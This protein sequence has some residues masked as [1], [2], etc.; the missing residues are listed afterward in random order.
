M[1]DV[2]SADAEAERAEGAVGGGVAVAGGDDHAGH[3]EALLGGDD[4]LDTLAAGASTS[5]ISMPKSRA[6]AAK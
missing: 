3:D 1:L 5:K 6:F 2:R 4:M